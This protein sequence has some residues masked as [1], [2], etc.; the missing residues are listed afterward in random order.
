MD[1]RRR[2]NEAIASGRVPADITAEFLGE[3]RDGP[4]MVGIMLVPMITAA[5]VVC[6][7]LARTLMLQR[8]G[9]DD[10]LALAS[11]RRGANDS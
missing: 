11:L 9:V 2:I 1:D 6:R 8:F 7:L 10:G 3:S 5:I 4:A